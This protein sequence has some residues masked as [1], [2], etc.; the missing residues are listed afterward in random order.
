[1]A[2]CATALA[3]LAFASQAGR[4][5]SLPGKAPFV[6]VPA[7]RSGTL[8]AAARP[9]KVAAPAELIVPAIG[10][11]SALVRL[12]RTAAGTLQVPASA[13]VAGW[14][15]ASP[16]P[17]ELGA[18]VIAGHVDSYQ[19][20]GVFFRLRLLRPR[21]LILIRRTDGSLAAFRVMT[22]R[23]YL[24]TRFP[25][26]AVYG[27]VPAAELRLITCGGIFDPGTGSYLSN[28]IVSAVA[29]RWRH[30]VRRHGDAVRGTA[31]SSVTSRRE[32]TSR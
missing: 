27:P 10:V 11:K 29:V 7:G 25:A 17:G 8:P 4:A 1:M 18:A 26:S 6:A 2:I 28:V 19:G 15:T 32:A 21:D 3:G 31:S 13:A 12:G 14:Y 30:G 9:V 16:R 5:A 24:K 20:P 23:T 22:V